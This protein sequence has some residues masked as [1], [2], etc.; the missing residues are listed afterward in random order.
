MCSCMTTETFYPTLN[1]DFTVFLLSPSVK[2]SSTNR[3][4]FAFKFAKIS[5]SSSLY[6]YLYPWL[7]HNNRP[8]LPPAHGA[9][10]CL[11][12]AQESIYFQK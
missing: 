3:W 2:E 11:P 12:R 7:V 9:E 4:C 8:N 5:P 6:P 1:A 10:L